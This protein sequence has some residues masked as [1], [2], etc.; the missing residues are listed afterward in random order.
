ML[1]QNH[2][3]AALRHAAA[4]PGKL[5]A[6]DT[7]LY[8]PDRRAAA[9]WIGKVVEPPVADDPDWAH[10]RFERPYERPR[11]MWCRIEYLTKLL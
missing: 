5:L 1:D 6:G 10:V 3:I 4:T 9:C 8:R 2:T 11:M 7:V